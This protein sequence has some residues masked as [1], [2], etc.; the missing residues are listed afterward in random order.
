MSSASSELAVPC[1]SEA[2]AHWDQEANQP[3]ETVLVHSER[4]ACAALRRL[5]S[6]DV[7]LRLLVHAA[8]LLHDLGKATPWF[9]RYLSGCEPSSLRSRHSM[10]G[11]A[12][13]WRLT[14][15]WPLDLRSSL[16]QAV[17]RHHGRLRCSPI[18]EVELLRGQLTRPGEE[19]HAVLEDQLAHIDLEGLTAWLGKRREQLGLSV[20]TL[21]P[22]TI[23]ES[24]LGITPLQ[25]K[26][27]LRSAGDRSFGAFL[28]DWT[29]Y[30]ALIG[31]DRIDTAAAGETV[32]RVELPRSPVERYVT[33]RFGEPRDE[34]GRLR[35]KISDE[36]RTAILARGDEQRLFTLTAPTG[37]GKTLAVLR[38]VL[39]Q[40]EARLDRG[41]NASRIIYCLPYTSVIDQNH[42]VCAEVLSGGRD[43][44]LPTDVLLKHHHLT[45]KSYRDSTDREWE[46]DGAAPLLVE[47]WQSEVVFSTFH[48][49]LHTFLSG[50]S[51][52]AIRA[53]AW[54]GATI[55]L[56]EVQAIPLEYWAAVGRLLVEASRTLDA[57][58]VLMTA[59]R[60]LI[61]PDGEGSELLAD[62]KAYF[63]ELDRVDLELDYDHETTLE[64][65][66][67][68]ALEARERG[69]VLLVLNT[70]A[71]VRQMY[72]LLVARFGKQQ[73][74]A[75]S[76]TLTPCDRKRRIA[77]IGERAP[78]EPLI[79]VSTQLVEA[80]VDLSFSTVIRD[81]APLDCV[82]QSAGRSNRHGGFE[83][84]RVRLVSMAPLEGH[85]LS[86]SRQVY[87]SVLLEATRDAIGHVAGRERV[88]GEHR[89]LELSEV[90]FRTCRDRSSSADVDLLA[91][92]GEYEELR[93]HF[94]LI[95]ERAHHLWLVRR[96]AEAE[97]VWAEWSDG[98]LALD[99]EERGTKG[100][101]AARTR[102][103]RLRQRLLEH[104]VQEPARSED[105]DERIRELPG[106]RYH[107]AVG[108]VPEGWT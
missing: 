85:R 22:E 46:V 76:T 80:G 38:A 36:V 75:L 61:F 100:W 77:E 60:P 1:W 98:I 4:T 45:S 44:P 3:T 52:D 39:G 83:R 16:F 99:E 102:L 67:D 18:R 108:L 43:G 31:A 73:V 51:Q 74:V 47:S 101:F 23:V 33:E 50:R 29:A 41:E 5:G 25:W 91:A 15:R 32:G 37:S 95:E 49:L 6:G 55:V 79:V 2:A 69:A 27:A 42:A 28:R 106:E 87:D 89:F 88:L 13:A 71:A 82:I 84:G 21:T 30:G 20:R 105:S 78:K 19:T 58:F 107:S 96:G 81:M 54:V 26:R 70:R 90:Y 64:Q 86:P 7:D 56:D 17:L 8:A 62:H 24:L 93:E 35:A 68:Q 59:T 66:V 65:L 53:P 9:Q 103:R 57:R 11:A 34:M 14:E 72:S 104:V 97:T 92:A 94:V 40:R 48:Q 63:S 10:V 12:V